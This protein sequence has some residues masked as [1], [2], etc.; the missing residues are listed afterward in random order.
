MLTQSKSTVV[1]KRANTGGA[2]KLRKGLVG[3]I[4]G[5]VGK[6]PNTL[7]GKKCPATKLTFHS[8]KGKVLVLALVHRIILASSYITH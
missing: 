2:T 8:E 3:Q 1:L 7:Y 6:F 4:K 5:L